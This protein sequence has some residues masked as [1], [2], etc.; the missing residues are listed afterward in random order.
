MGSPAISWP[1]C[2]AI[3]RQQEAAPCAFPAT[4]IDFVLVSAMLELL[5]NQNRAAC[6]VLYR[7]VWGQVSS[8]AL[9]SIEFASAN[10]SGKS[11]TN[12]LHIRDEQAKSHDLGANEDV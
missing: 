8:F 12:F 9:S 6:L 5:I 1:G 7:G 4:T 11:F 2:R 3:A 10:A